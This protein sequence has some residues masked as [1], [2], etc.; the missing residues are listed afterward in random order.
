MDDAH[1]QYFFN[2]IAVQLNQRVE[3]MNGVVAPT[4]SRWRED[5]QL[6][7]EG[8]VENADR[9]KVDYEIEQRRKRT[10]QESTGEIWK[11]NFFFE[12]PHPFLRDQSGEAMK[13]WCLVE[14]E[15]GYWERRNRG[16]WND[17]PNLWGPFEENQ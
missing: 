7:E 16:D 1:L 8:D 15:K 2:E 11:P 5:I 6:Y 9:V 14:G 13:Q 4:D 3:G 12:K 17:L 10:H